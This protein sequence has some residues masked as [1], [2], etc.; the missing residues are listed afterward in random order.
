MLIVTTPLHRRKRKGK[1]G[2]RPLVA[3]T[4]LETTQG[5]EWTNLFYI[6]QALTRYD[7]SS[8]SMVGEP[9]IIAYRGREF[10]MI[11]SL[12]PIG[13]GVSHQQPDGRLEVNT[14]T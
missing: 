6:F 2:A 9:D 5:V 12:P 3:D 4:E 10:Q 13:W 7:W 11:K 1:R 8:W 14:L